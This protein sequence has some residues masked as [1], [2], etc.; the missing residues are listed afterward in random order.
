MVKEHSKEHKQEQRETT[1]KTSSEYTIT[2]PEDQPSCPH[3]RVPASKKVCK[4][5]YS[6]TINE[7]RKQ[8]QITAR[9]KHRDIAPHFVHHTAL[10]AGYS[11]VP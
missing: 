1:K 8:G 9:L 5:K 6:S 2:L 4:T 3:N 11:R 7:A 10:T